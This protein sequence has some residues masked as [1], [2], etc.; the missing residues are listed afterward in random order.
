MA[1]L[2]LC[3]S[4]PLQ[5]WGSSSRF[6]TRQTNREPTKSG[7]I[8]MISAALGIRREDSIDI[9]SQLNEMKLGIRVD[10]EGTLL[11]DF[12]TAK[13]KK[14]AY[15]TNR[16]Y[17]SDAVFLVGLETSNTELL[18]QIDYAISHPVFPLF[19]GRRSCPPTLPVAMG[20]KDGDLHSVLTG[21]PSLCKSDN[22]SVR[23]VY[24]SADGGA[25]INDVPLSFSQKHRS[26]GYRYIKE[27]FVTISEKPTEHD[28]MSEV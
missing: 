25:I 15:V 9:I 16:Y 27:E 20:I 11:R 14:S 2:L 21:F 17:L 19:L 1:V 12:H 5:S 3:L 6:D 13:S 24:E 18:K 23:Y 22:R 7:V 8:G 28:A 26:Y 4:G 10:R